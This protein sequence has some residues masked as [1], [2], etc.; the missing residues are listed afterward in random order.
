M[1]EKKTKQ[2]LSFG[3]RLKVFEFLKNV[4]K[5]NDD[6]VS[7]YDEG[8][9]DVRVAEVLKVTP[10]NVGSIRT[11]MIGPLRRAVTSGSDDVQ[12][13]RERVHALEQEVGQLSGRLA[14]L[15]KELGVGRQ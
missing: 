10:T 14:H 3:E 1:S 15:E 5:K 13:L 8:W 9:T 2:T 4:C 12:A 11:Q 7:S 6:G